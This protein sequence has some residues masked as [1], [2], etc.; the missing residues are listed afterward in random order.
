MLK[1]VGETPK[2]GSFGTAGV[3]DF[4]TGLVLLLDQPSGSDLQKP[5]AT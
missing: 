5:P 3:G 1:Y 2:A 4:L